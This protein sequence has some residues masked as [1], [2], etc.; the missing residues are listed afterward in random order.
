MTIYWDMDGTIANFYEV[1]NWLEY[2][3]NND[4][5]PYLAAKPC[6]EPYKLYILMETLI[7]MGFQQGIISWT[8]KDGNPDFNKD[9]RKAKLQWLENEFI[10]DCFSEIHI[11]KYGTKKYS[12]AKD[13]G[14]ILIDDDKKVRQD[15]ERAGGLALN[16][17]DDDILEKLIDI[18]QEW[19]N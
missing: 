13:K 6:F 17:L 2:L 11:I 5:F 16:P 7:A 18:A 9:I 3:C 19:Y 10:R 12:V 8:S 14:A 4:V 1:D 15:W